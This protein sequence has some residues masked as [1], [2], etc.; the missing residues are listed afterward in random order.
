MRD[1]VPIPLVPIPLVPIPLVPLS[2]L[3]NAL[4]LNSELPNDW[5]IAHISAIYKKG[6]KQLAENYR[7]VSLTSILVKQLES[8][9]RE[10]IIQHMKKLHLFSN[11]QFGFFS[12]RSTVLQVLIVLDIWTEIIIIIIYIYI[13]QHPANTACSTRL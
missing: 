9:V 6:A 10:E 7:P 4:I 11:K 2:I 5:K 12:G 8:L 3:F 1:I 13:A